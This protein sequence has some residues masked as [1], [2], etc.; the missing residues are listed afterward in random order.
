[1]L[2]ADSG[3]LS[4][5]QTAALEKHL[6]TCESCREY[7]RQVTQMLG[8]MS[9]LNPASEPAEAVLAN[10]RRAAAEEDNKGQARLFVPVLRFAACAAA[11]LLLLAGLHIFRVSENGEKADQLRIAQLGSLVEI[12]SDEEA[13]TFAEDDGAESTGLD[14]LAERLL[15]F[16]GLDMDEQAY[17]DLMFAEDTHSKDLQSRSTRVSPQAEY[18]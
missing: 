8:D 4:A 9:R 7:A 18:V 6:V 15:R 17:E 13:S 16:Q 14:A 5:R 1:M 11:L 12:L 10:I 2:L 3:E